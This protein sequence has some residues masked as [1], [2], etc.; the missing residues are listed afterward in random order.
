MRIV[1]FPLVLKNRRNKT[2]S[3]VFLYCRY[4]LFLKVPFLPDHLEA[5]K[6]VVAPHGIDKTSPIHQY[7]VDIFSCPGPSGI[8]GSDGKQN[9]A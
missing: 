9:M 6:A 4:S 1:H 7:S 2:E 5:T 8:L 3:A